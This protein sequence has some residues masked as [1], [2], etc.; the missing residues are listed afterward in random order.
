[1]QP[2]MSLATNLT[3]IF[4]TFQDVDD[5]LQILSGCFLCSSIETTNSVS[6]EN[7]FFRSGTETPCIVYRRQC[8]PADDEA[9]LRD[10]LNCSCYSDVFSSFP[11][12]LCCFAPEPTENPA[13]SESQPIFDIAEDEPHF[14]QQ[15]VPGEYSAT[16]S[17][18][19][20]CGVPDKYVCCRDQSPE[21]LPYSG[22]V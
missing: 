11:G 10:N 19:E 13:S 15:P 5:F 6:L 22:G 2:D 4:G 1:M 20:F 17:K 14:P 9:P 21:R 8:D 16:G 3:A 7:V 18:V 12:L